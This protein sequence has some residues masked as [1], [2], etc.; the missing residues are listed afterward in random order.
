MYNA[1][2]PHISQ[3]ELRLLLHVYAC[4]CMYMCMNA[5]MYKCMYI[6]ITSGTHIFHR[7]SYVCCC[8]CMY[9]CMNVCMYKCMYICIT[10]GTRIFH[11]RSYVC[12]CISAPIRT[13]C[14]SGNTHTHI[15]MHIHMC[16]YTHASR[17]SLFYKSF[18]MSTRTLIYML[19]YGNEQ[20][21]H[22]L[23]WMFLC[24]YVCVYVHMYVCTYV[25]MYFPRKLIT[26]DSF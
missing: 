9:M 23:P 15:Q 11:R 4:L 25:C 16:I 26:F 20:S 6:C 8:T 13:I 10:S 21:I 22:V 5:C 18:C 1:W 2:H 24:A 19:S 3:A 17:C 14:F 12:C 7:R